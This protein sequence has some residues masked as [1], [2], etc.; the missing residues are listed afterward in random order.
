MKNNWNIQIILKLLTFIKIFNHV[1]NMSYNS[2]HKERLSFYDACE[3]KKEC[4]FIFIS[5]PTL[6]L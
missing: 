3:W 2:S 5:K 1:K 6:N 4:I